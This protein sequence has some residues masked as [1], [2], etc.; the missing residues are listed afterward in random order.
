MDRRGQVLLFVVV[1]AGVLALFASTL[2]F[3]IMHEGRWSSKQK[4]SSIA[5]QLAEAG[6]NRGLWKL[7][8]RSNNWDDIPTG[9]FY[10]NNPGYN[11]DVIYQSSADRPTWKYRI[12]ITTTAGAEE[13]KII[14]T[15]A[16]L[17]P[18]STVPIDTRAVEIILS[19]AAITSAIDAPEVDTSG[20]VLV[21][22]GP[23]VAHK[24]LHFSGGAKVMF[25]RKFSVGQITP[26]PPYLGGVDRGPDGGHNNDTDGTPQDPLSGSWH[27]WN[28]VPIPPAPQVATA[29]YMQAAKDEE[30]TLYGGKFVQH[31]FP[32]GISFSNLRD[33]IGDTK[34]YSHLVGGKAVEHT[35][36]A[37]G[38]VK[39]S[40]G[41]F[42]MG[43]LISED[44]VSLSGGG[45][46][47]YT[48][49][50]LGYQAP[51]TQAWREYGRGTVLN[52]IPSP[53]AW[54]AAPANTGAVSEYPADAGGHVPAS[55]NPMFEFGNAA[56]T[57]QTGTKQAVS[58][59]GFINCKTF[60]ASG[61]T[62]IHGSILVGDTVADAGGGVQVYFRDGM[63]IQLSASTPTRT[64][65]KEI[66]PSSYGSW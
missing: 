25:P 27:A 4:R 32:G 14:G 47:A 22:W 33:D 7:Q 64:S 2:F 24:E 41:Y 66:L 6:A 8:E 39:L 59:Y 20:G 28:D 60:T 53:P 10:T 11:N 12:Q 17:R 45:K 35:R 9:V 55:V 1:V 21:H 34:N 52:P 37:K 3:M 62:V 40:G 15:G 31:Y 19:K 58:W 26:D 63:K 5:F 38:T 44:T 54:D 36:Y 30:A 61:G 29:A 46:G 16:V 50:L 57:L 42:G 65:W 56:L 48:A 43:V 23:I 13:R 51:P 18:G 49:G